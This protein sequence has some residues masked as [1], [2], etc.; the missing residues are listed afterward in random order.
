M[1]SSNRAALTG[2]LLSAFLVVGLTGLFAIYA[3]P[4]P[5]QRALQREALLDEALE[6]ATAP[7]AASRL[8]ALREKLADMAD[9]VLSGPGSA[10]ERIAH[11]R[12]ET[13][14]RMDSEAAEIALRLRWL[15]I[16]VTLCAGGFGAALFGLVGKHAGEG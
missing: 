14:A 16:I 10:Q 11:V 13:M 5:L 1:K 9:A 2:F 15:V 12:A 4:V 6:A 8:P 7:D 3:A